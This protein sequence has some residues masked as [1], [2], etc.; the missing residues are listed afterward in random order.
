MTFVTLEI[1]LCNHCTSIISRV[2]LRIRRWNIAFYKIEMSRNQVPTDKAYLIFSL[3]FRAPRELDTTQEIN[4][5][6]QIE[7][8]TGRLTTNHLSNHHGLLA[9]AAAATAGLATNSLFYV[10]FFV[11]KIIFGWT[12]NQ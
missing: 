4:M 3:Y 8:D 6:Q 5:S 11:T 1:R 12:T 2:V 7:I 9:A 10:C